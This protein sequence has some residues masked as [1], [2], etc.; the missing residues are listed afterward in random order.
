M[1]K[2]C[3]KITSIIML[4]IL[5]SS[6]YGQGIDPKNLDYSDISISIDNG[7]VYTNLQKHHLRKDDVLHHLPVWLGLNHHFSFKEM[8]QKNDDLGFVHITLVPFYKNIKVSG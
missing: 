2:V 6:I 1:Q 7:S 5:S 3:L 8:A 4:V